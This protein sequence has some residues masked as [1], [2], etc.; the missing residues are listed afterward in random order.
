[1]NNTFYGKLIFELSQN[2]RQGYSLPEN[3]C[4]EYKMSDLPKGLTL[5]PRK[6]RRACRR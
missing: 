6:R 2:G 4:A 3:R 1:M 5:W